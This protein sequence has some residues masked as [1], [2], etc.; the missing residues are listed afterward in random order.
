MA[1]KPLAELSL[2][3]LLKLRRDLLAEVGRVE[4]ELTERGSPPP[5]SRATRR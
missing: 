5:K 2:E 1:D 4:K 3:A